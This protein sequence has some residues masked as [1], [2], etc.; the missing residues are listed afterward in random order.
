MHGG[1]LDQSTRAFAA[2]EDGLPGKQKLKMVFTIEK[3]VIAI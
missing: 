2:S 1:Y 3:S